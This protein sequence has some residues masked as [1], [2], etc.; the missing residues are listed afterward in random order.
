MEPNPFL[1][2]FLHFLG[3]VAAASFYVPFGKVKQ[4]S[5]ESCWLLMCFIGYLIAP[6]VVVWWTVPDL[7]EVYS[8]S[9]LNRVAM[10]YAFG[11]MWGVGGLT[12][13]LTLRYLGIS[14]GMAISLGL[15]TAFG[16]L[17]PPIYKGEFGELLR[18][19][20]GQ[21]VLL[22]VV[23]CLVGIAMC[24]YAGIRKER[25]L[26]DE[27]K[28][29]GVK[30]FNL[31][32]GFVVAVIAGV[33][34]ASMA[35][36]IDWGKEIAKKAVELG[37]RDHFQENPVLLLLMVGNFTTNLIWCLALNVKNRS[38]GDYV[39][40][41]PRLLLVN[42]LLIGLAGVLAYNE[43]FW[44]G[45]GTTKMG[46]YD[47]SS[48]SI[49]LAFVIIVSNL[50]GILLKEWKGVRLGTW[51]FLWGAMAIL[52]LSTIVM[53]EGSRKSEKEVDPETVTQLSSF[54]DNISPYKE[55]R[56]CPT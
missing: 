28:E 36:G 19:R 41:T 13:G 33:M 40:G 4:W 50:W 31:L 42:Y 49:H 9:S 38:I 12:F 15:C 44:Y 16:T 27:E 21:T 2:V 54:P 46:E 14:L 22:G 39:S 7:L 1:G 32:K 11:T 53:A 56:K 8:Q 35:F 47:F 20:S 45:M 52:A 26:T 48:W 3:G 29:E 55:L 6:C 23:M 5:W 43:F 37:V 30:E 17:I 10:V 34:S 24:G 25:E 51:F 18:N